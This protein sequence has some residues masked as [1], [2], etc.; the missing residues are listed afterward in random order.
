MEEPQGN[1]AI[2]WH[3]KMSMDKMLSHAHSKTCHSFTYEVVGSALVDPWIPLRGKILG[4]CWT[5]P[6]KCQLSGSQKCQSNVQRY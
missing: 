1:W 2:K 6:R 5:G 4:F 3:L